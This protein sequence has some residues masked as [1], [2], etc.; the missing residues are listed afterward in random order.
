[1]SK[2]GSAAGSPEAKVTKDRWYIDTARNLMWQQ[3]GSEDLQLFLNLGKIE[4]ME[5]FQKKINGDLINFVTFNLEGEPV[6][7]LEFLFV[8]C[9]WWAFCSRALQKYA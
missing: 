9:F 1:M 5:R 6:L 7:H 3:H 8:L 4:S 2:K